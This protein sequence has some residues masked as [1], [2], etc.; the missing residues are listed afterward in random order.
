MATQLK[1][2]EIVNEIN[3]RIRKDYQFEHSVELSPDWSK[4]IVKT[5]G[6]GV[7]TKSKEE[8]NKNL[9]IFDYMLKEIIKIVSELPHELIAELQQ[10]NENHVDAVLDDYAILIDQLK[11]N[12]SDV[13][14]RNQKL[15]FETFFDFVKTCEKEYCLSDFDNFTESFQEKLFE[16]IKNVIEPSASN[17]IVR[18]LM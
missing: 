6:E 11:D 3:L 13:T 9:L 12:P 8:F 1:S 18:E 17:R 16:H 15:V 7:N 14:L 2:F 10:L 4:A 5:I